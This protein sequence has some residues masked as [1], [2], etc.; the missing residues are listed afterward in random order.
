MAL[1]S[2]NIYGKY[3]TNNIHWC[4]CANK[5]SKDKTANNYKIRLLT[6]RLNFYAKT[7]IKYIDYNVISVL[8][9]TGILFYTLYLFFKKNSYNYIKA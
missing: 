9:G 5:I 3:D 7:Y 4:K 2:N 1:N 8:A 6:A